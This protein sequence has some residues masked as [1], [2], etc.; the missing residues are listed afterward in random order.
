METWTRLGQPGGHSF[1]ENLERDP[2]VAGRLSPEALDEAMDAGR[3]L[4][5]VDHVFERVFGCS[6]AAM[7]AA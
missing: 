7:R 4:R 5:A 3:H 2:D 1:R 6:K